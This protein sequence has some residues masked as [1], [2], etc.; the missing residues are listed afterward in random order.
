MP[1]I[2]ME[3]RVR[4]ADPKEGPKTPGDMCYL[5]YKSMVEAWK[6]K[7]SWT[8]FHQMLS[9][10]F[11]WNDHQT[12]KVAALMVFFH[13]HVMKYEAEKKLANGDI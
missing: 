8:L 6:A 12:A 5:F 4:L 10:T 1:F 9:S 7:P 11:G 3:E 2:P 13:E